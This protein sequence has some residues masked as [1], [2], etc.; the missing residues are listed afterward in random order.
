MEMHRYRYRYTAK[1]TVGGGGG[2]GLAWIQGYKRKGVLLTGNQKRDQ[3]LLRFHFRD[4]LQQFFFSLGV[5]P[6]ATFPTQPPP[7]P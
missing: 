5:Y 6:P 1:D 3:D 7:P 4:H 2:G